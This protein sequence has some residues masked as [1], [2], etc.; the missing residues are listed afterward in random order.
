MSRR[1]G[2]Y[3]D[4][5]LSKLVLVLLVLAVFIPQDKLFPILKSLFPIVYVLLAIFLLRLTISLYQRWRLSQTDIYDIDDMDGSEFE[6]RLAVLYKNL[7]YNVTRIGGTGDAGVDLIVEKQ[8]VKTAVQ[9]KRYKN[10]VPEA[11]V[12]QVHTGKDYY[13]CDKAII[14]TNS[15]FTPMAQEVANATGIKLWNRNY[16]IKVLLTEH[17]QLSREQKEKVRNESSGIEAIEHGAVSKPHATPELVAYI[18]KKIE[19]GAN[20][21][22]VQAAMQ[23]AGWSE[24]VLNDA[25]FQVF[26]AK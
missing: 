25:F 5:E 3:S 11:A 20:W 7:G 21:L 23:K 18:S 17:D 15:F 10:N 9:A 4:R 24:E 13:H 8:G 22:D 2:R 19:S 1:H 26:N 6:E 14:V 12:Q 16:L